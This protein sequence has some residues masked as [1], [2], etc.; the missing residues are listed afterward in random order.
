MVVATNLLALLL[1][2]LV[3]E[4]AVRLFRL[5]PLTLTVFKPHPARMFALAP[6]QDQLFVGR[7]FA[8]RV[9]IGPDGF[10]VPAGAPRAGAGGPRVL[11]LGDSMTFGYGVEAEESWPEVLETLLRKD[12]R[13]DVEVINAGVVAYAP[14]QQLD[15][16]RELLPRVRP[17][18]VVLGLYP[19]NDLAEVMLHS[20]APPMTVSP[21]GA[22]LTMATEADLHP[23]PV[24]LWLTRHLRLYS[25]M[26][27]KVHRTLTSFGLTEKPVLYHPAYF[28]DALGYTDAYE[29]NW[30]K[31]EGLLA[32]IDVE[33]KAAGGRLLL[34][35][36]PMDVQVSE[37]YWP[38]LQ[39]LGFTL[40]PVMLREA[41]PQSRLRRFAE[42]AGVQMRDLL[43]VFRAHTG[44][45][46]YFDHDPHLTPAGQALVAKTV[47]PEV[48][49]LLQAREE[50]NSPGSAE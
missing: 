32:A 34:V 17:D 50:G 3:G 11:A 25:Y 12:D 30:E 41:R 33:T 39:G 1:V 18:V 45:R 24:G 42:G 28:A 13:P 37:K 2:V 38:Y 35:V 26:R 5:A 48:A 15:Q 16:L 31:L 40:A 23:N 27:V 6:E 21:E 44:E 29:E 36:I 47:L 46:L 20:S 22:L 10:R 8:T 4:A 19:G 43:P 14:D 9:I 7:D 49:H